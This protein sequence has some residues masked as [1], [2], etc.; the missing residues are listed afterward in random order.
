M[1]EKEI[2]TTMKAATWALFDRAKSLEPVT[3]I[4]GTR[5]FISHLVNIFNFIDDHENDKELLEC[6]RIVNRAWYELMEEKNTGK[7]YQDV[8][9]ALDRLGHFAF[10]KR[11]SI[12]DEHPFRAPKEVK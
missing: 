11:Y 6:T 9:P 8:M 10:D 3:C 12:P 7:A 5:Q 2:P 4:L 1:T